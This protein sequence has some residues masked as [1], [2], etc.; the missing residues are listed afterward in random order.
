MNL[1]VLDRQDGTARVLSAARLV[2][3]AR[4][5]DCVSFA[6]RRFEHGFKAV[7]PS[8]TRRAKGWKIV[9]VLRT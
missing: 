8:P 1:L 9:E 7:V 2:E 3:L 6:L 5:P 4:D